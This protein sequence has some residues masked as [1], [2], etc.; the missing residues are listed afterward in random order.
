MAHGY[1]SMLADGK[2]LRDDIR[3]YYFEMVEKINREWWNN[4]AQLKEPLRADGVFE[5]I[6]QRDGTIVSLRLIRGSGSNAADRLIAESIRKASP[7][8]PLPSTYESD[9]FNVPLKIKAPLSLFR[10]KN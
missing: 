1:F 9:Q 4:A 8:P 5:V 6:V 7:L 10:V 3:A 2:T